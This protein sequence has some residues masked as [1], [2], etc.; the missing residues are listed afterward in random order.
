MTFKCIHGLCPSYL[1][2]T[3]TFSIV[4]NCVDLAVP[5]SNSVYGDRA[6]ATAGPRIWNVLPRELRAI[7]DVK[8]FKKSLKTY[9]F[10]QADALYAR[11][12]MK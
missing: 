4:R 7:I 9:L 5:T 11:L 6:F 8:I 10:V 12:N 1:S 2:D 3:I